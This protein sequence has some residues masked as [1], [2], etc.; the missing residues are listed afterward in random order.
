M[1]TG[2]ALPIRQLRHPSDAERAPPMDEQEIE[3]ALSLLLEDMEDQGADSHEIFLRLDQ[4]FN[5]MRALGMPP[6]DDLVRL[7]DEL[8]AEFGGP[9]ESPAD[10][11]DG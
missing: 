8:A 1:T 9:V 10:Q 7:H 3:V 11:K 5:S 4:L 6:P 2:R